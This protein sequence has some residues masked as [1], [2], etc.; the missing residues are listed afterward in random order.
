MSPL[1]EYVTLFLAGD[2]IIF[3]TE[4][5]FGNKEL[6]E[7]EIVDKTADHFLV[8]TKNSGSYKV[9]NHQIMGRK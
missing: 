7:G 6:H 3:A 8:H 9:Y 2:T 1:E 5:M 4:D